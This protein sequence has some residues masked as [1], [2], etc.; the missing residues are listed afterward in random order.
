MHIWEIP[1]PAWLE[2]DL[3]VLSQNMRE[4][5][6]ITS[7]KAKIM[8]V[9]KANA[10]GH[11]AERVA[12]VL[13][14]NGADRL[15]VATLG[16]GII[17]R[18]TGIKAPI[19]VL[20]H[21]PK[22]HVDMALAYDINQTV[23]GYEAA[24]AISEKAKKQGKTAV[25]HI[26]LDTGMGRIGFLPGAKGVEQVC[27]IMQLPSLYVEGIYTH[28]PKADSIDKS[29]TLNQCRLFDEFVAQVEERGHKFALRHVAN[30]AALVDMPQTHYD[31]VRPGI[32]LFGHY[33]SDEVDHNKINIASAMTLKAVVSHVKWVPKGASISY[34]CAYV[35]DEPSLIASLPLGYGDGYSRRFSN[36]GQVLIRGK[37][38]PV[39]GRVCM[40]QMMVN[41]TG[42]SDLQVG[43]EVVI[44]GS[45]GD[46]SITVE[47]IAAAEGTINYEIMCML[48]ERLPRIYINK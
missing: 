13:L 29:F 19:M 8:A 32:I 47:E 23:Y 27:K 7:L 20:G 43:E 3:G 38:F 21:V 4:V 11:G 18:D 10:Y 12:E 45:Q 5:R 30:S 24:L 41:V 31:M 25:I 22:G 44:I 48:S 2:I 1:R 14:A 34:E 6:R 9:V 35:T 42:L 16:E 46:E 26:K 37:R 17:L 15:G 40:D 36:Y 39:V 28:F 33:P